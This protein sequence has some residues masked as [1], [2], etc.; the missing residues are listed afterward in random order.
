M[1]TTVTIVGNV[2]RDPEL[3]MIPSGAAIATFSIAVSKRRKNEAGQWEDGD[4]EF[5]DVVAWRDL[6]EN[7]VESIVKG[8]RVIV[9]GRLS[10][11]SWE[12]DD[13][14]KRSKVEI[15]ADE[16]GPSLKW[17][18]TEIHRTERSTGNFGNNYDREPF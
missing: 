10:Q 1:T 5:Y 4:T 2:T 14:Q 9:T 11:R 6:G 7:V 15:V 17:A 8:T 3:R 12:T 16:V 18:T 13:G